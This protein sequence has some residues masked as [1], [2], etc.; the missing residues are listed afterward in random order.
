[1]AEYYRVDITLTDELGFTNAY[2]LT[3]IVEP[4]PVVES[5]SEPEAEPEEP[6][7]DCDSTDD[8][9]ADFL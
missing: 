9:C 5:E 1:V 6:A 7:C 3:V 4:A 2:Y 8:A